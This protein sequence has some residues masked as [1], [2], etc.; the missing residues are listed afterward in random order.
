[1]MLAGI[2]VPDDDVSELA[3]LV[4]EPTASLLEKALELNTVILALT[5][6]DAS[7]SSE[8]STIRLTDSPSSAVCFSASMSG[9]FARGSGSSQ[10]AE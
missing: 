2:R 9:A 8:R 4:D 5:V 6:D 3:G 1:M 7:E 10:G